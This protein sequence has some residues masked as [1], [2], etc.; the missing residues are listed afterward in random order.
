MNRAGVDTSELIR[1]ART[2]IAIGSPESEAFAAAENV[3]TSKVT[4]LLLSGRQGAGK[5][6]VAPRVLARLDIP[7]VQVRVSDAIRAELDVVISH[8]T[9]F[10]K[11]QAA[12]HIAQD[13]ALEQRHAEA[14]VEILWPVTRDPRHGITAHTRTAEVRKALQYHGLDSRAATDPD[15]WVRACFRRVVSHLSTGTSVYLTD[16]RYPNEVDTARALGMFCVRLLVEAEVQA[17]RI[18]ARDGA[19]PDPATLN[20][21]GERVLD[22]YDGFDV[23]LDN[24]K[25]LADTVDAV[26][27]R[28][29]ATTRAHRS[30]AID[31]RALFFRQHLAGPNASA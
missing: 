14:L 6:T 30:S 25:H 23:V 7:A 31:W 1:I 3:A 17:A 11:P 22:D 26:A 28:L 10:G 18:T 16:S 13:L 21:H 29:Q 5:D 24:S 12:R 19:A 4:G 8:A 9:A 15:Y 20:H 2:A 27:A